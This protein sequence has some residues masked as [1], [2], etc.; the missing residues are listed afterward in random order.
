MECALLLL[1]STVVGVEDMGTRK[2]CRI[3]PK[4]AHFVDQGLA[5]IAISCLVI[6]KKANVCKASFVKKLLQNKR[7]AN[8]V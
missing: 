1:S 3:L 4:T 2:L 7:K 6:F 5:D 8:D